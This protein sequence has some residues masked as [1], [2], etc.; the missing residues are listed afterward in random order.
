MWA[1][2]SN[3]A[4]SKT[5]R[6]VRIGYPLA[7]VFSPVPVRCWVAVGAAVLLLGCGHMAK[8]LMTQISERRELNA[9]FADLFDSDGNEVYLKRAACYCVLGRTTPWLS[10]QKV[11]RDRRE[12]AIGYTK[13]GQSPL[14]NPPH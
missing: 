3:T 9:V 6:A 4:R 1:E 13:L 11:A 2:G 12:V 7:R 5:L 14:I 10:V 8:L